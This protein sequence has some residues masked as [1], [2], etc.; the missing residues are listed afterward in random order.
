[1][2]NLDKEKIL[3]LSDGAKG[4]NKFEDSESENEEDLEKEEEAEEEEE[5]ESLIRYH[6]RPPDSYLLSKGISSTT[7]S[8][9]LRT[10]LIKWEALMSLHYFSGEKL[11]EMLFISIGI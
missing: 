11:A 7:V 6:L 4:K 1:M 8:S 10:G 3:L 2:K 5:K 9:L